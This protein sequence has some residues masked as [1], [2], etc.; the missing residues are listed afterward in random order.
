M[1]KKLDGKLTLSRE[2]LR[3]LEQC[4]LRRVEGARTTGECTNGF[5]YCFICP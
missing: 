1:K 4:A 3:L 2:S 5:T